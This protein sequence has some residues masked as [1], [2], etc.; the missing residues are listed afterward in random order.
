MA[1]CYALVAWT[2]VLERRR[3]KSAMLLKVADAAP[4]FADGMINGVPLI[5]AAHNINDHVVE[6]M[7]RWLDGVSTPWSLLR[8]VDTHHASMFSLSGR[9]ADSLKGFVAETLVKDH[10]T[11]LGDH[12]QLMDTTNNPIVDILI[13][14][15]SYQVKSGVSAAYHSHAHLLNYPDVPVITDPESAHHV[16]QFFPHS[17]L[18]VPE[19]A[20]AKLEAITS[21][22]LHGL[23]VLH[24]AGAFHIPVITVGIT[25]YQE[26][27]RLTQGH[28]TFDTALAHVGL[29]AAGV[30]IGLAGGAKAGTIIGMRFGLHGAAIGGAIGGLIGGIGGKLSAAFVKE[31]HLREL[32]VKYRGEVAIASQQFSFAEQRAAADFRRDLRRTDRLVK[33]DRQAYAKQVRQQHREAISALTASRRRLKRVLKRRTETSLPGLSHAVALLDRDDRTFV[34]V[35]IECGTVNGDADLLQSARS[36]LALLLHAESL[37][38]MEMDQYTYTMINHD[39]QIRKKGVDVL[40]GLAARAAR[41]FARCN[42]LKAEIETEMQ[43][44]GKKMPASH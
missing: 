20:N 37:L 1:C 27:S 17:V 11:A 43:K 38:S 25:S 24:H 39:A 8:Y 13:D 30:G 35:V 15:R 32:V 6:A 29:D 2:L 16:A 22:T 34:A 9:F 7:T 31:R 26:L 28:T 5:E 42:R 36:Y 10:F 14:G 12:V 44:L 40:D 41:L 33:R 3:R 4:G 18:G 23:D 19:I 21:G